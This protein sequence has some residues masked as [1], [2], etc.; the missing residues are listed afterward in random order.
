MLSVW[1]VFDWKEFSS[2]F[3]IENFY[4]VYNLFDIFDQL[5]HNFESSIVEQIFY[6]YSF[7]YM[8]IEVL[9]LIKIKPKYI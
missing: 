1:C 6:V 7:Y 4:L 5:H 8:L 9:F 2:R 3:S